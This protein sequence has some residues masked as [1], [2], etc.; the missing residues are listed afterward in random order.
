MSELDALLKEFEA[1]A[2]HIQQLVTDIRNLFTTKEE[3]KKEISFTDLRA[4]C[5]GKSRDGFTAKVK[6]LIVSMGANR[7]SEVE[8]N[9][10]EELYEKVED[11]K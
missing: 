5:A 4:L 8:P 7:L 11:L 9:R 2:D 6:E 10:Y 3:P 1:A